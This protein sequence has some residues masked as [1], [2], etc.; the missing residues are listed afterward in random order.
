MTEKDWET[1]FDLVDRIVFGSGSWKEKAS[2][3]REQASQYECE[4]NF[5][6]FVEW[7]QNKDDEIN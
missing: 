6:E 4:N 5:E 7:F 2:E 1:F 3:V